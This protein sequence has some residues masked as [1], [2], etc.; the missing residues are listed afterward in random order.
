MWGQEFPYLQSVASPGDCFAS[1]YLSTVTLTAQ[2]LQAAGE[3]AWGDGVDFS[4]PREQWF[5]DIAA[6]PRGT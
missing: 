4:L 3:A 1:G 5:T 6:T 2:E